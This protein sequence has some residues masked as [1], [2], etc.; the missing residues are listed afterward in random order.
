M[1]S[2]HCKMNIIPQ[3]ITRQASHIASKESMHQYV[4]T[5]T[6][7]PFL[8]ERKRVLGK[9]VC[10]DAFVVGVLFRSYLS[11]SLSAQSNV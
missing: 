2:I 9:S 4:Y 7:F 5:F 10:F 6:L 3:G 11:I 8:I 1:T